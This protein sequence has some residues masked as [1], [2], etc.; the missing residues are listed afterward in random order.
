MLDDMTTVTA[1]NALEAPPAA[2]QPDPTLV[3]RAIE[4]R[5]IATLATVSASG[6]PHAAT[7]IYQL[8]DGALFVSTQR[9]S[10]K[11]RNIA[12]TGRAAMTIA[13]RR[14]PVG[15]PASIQLQ[16]SASVLA[17][18]DPEVVGLARAGRLDRI[19]GHGELDLEGG[20][21]LRLALPSRLVT[22]AL[23]MSLWRVMRHPLEV[24]G[25]VDLRP[26]LP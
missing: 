25:E 12:A 21:F 8:A 10:R 2:F 19:T 5:S 11:A 15:P 7:V 17:I 20:C 18:D 9:D 22:Y 16:S 4:R 6:R 26:I 23:G 1:T 13:V 3:L 24:A 14:L